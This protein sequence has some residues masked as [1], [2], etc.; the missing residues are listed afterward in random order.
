MTNPAW[1]KKAT[2]EPIW[3]G[4][5]EAEAEAIAL[6]D[7]D[8][9][10]KILTILE[11]MQWPQLIIFKYSESDRVVAPFVVG[12]S[13]EGN[14]LMRGFQLEGV[15]RSGKGAGWR[16]FQINKMERVETHQE[17]FNADDFDFDEFYPWIYG[18]IKML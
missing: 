1:E 7:S 10:F 12:V 16:V 3:Q 11:A 8:T 5:T 9:R 18:V 6:F 14:P 15:S 17:F 4:P 13:S 2:D